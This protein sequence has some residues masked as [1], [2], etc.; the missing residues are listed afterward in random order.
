MIVS[1]LDVLP[2][3][4]FST[5]LVRESS[6]SALLLGRPS[7]GGLEAIETRLRITVGYSPMGEDVVEYSV[8]EGDNKA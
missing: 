3:R 5:L 8:M 6:D 7:E 4:L 1:G 2:R